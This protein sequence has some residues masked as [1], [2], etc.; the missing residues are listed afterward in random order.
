[1]GREYARLLA[2]DPARQAVLQERL[3]PSL[4]D[5][6]L[7]VEA[8][9]EIIC[10]T[11]RRAWRIRPPDRGH[12]G[13][14]SAVPDR[15][16]QGGHRLSGPG[17]GVSRPGVRPPPTPATDAPAEEIATYKQARKRQSSRRIC[18]EHAIAEHKQWRP[19]SATL[20]AARPTIR[21]IWPSQGWSPTGLPV[22]D[23]PS[24]GLIRPARPDAYRAP[25]RN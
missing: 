15:H 20:G 1:M 11:L 10:A 6:G 12:R 21:H 4:A 24:A 17:Q 2:Y 22:A 23:P 5:L 25:S 16:G 3:G 8:Q 13:A 19:Y 9:I 14:L 7:P 18:V